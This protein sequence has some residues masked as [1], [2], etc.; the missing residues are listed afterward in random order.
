MKKPIFFLLTIS[1]LLA[2]TKTSIGQQV[3][4][5][6]KEFYTIEGP[7]NFV[8]VKSDNNTK[9]VL[10]KAET[11][12]PDKSQKEMYYPGANNSNFKLVGDNIVIVYDIWQKAN[13]TKDCSIKLLDIKSG[14]FTAPKLLY[15]TKLNSPY[16]CSE[17][18]YKPIYS[19]DKTKLAVIK[20]NISPSYNIDPEINIYDTKTL[21]VLS[22]KKIS[23]KYDGQKRIF[24][25][26]TIA[27]DDKGNITTVF[28][29]MNEKTKITTKSYSADIPFAET[30]LKNIK[31]L[32]G[33]SSSDAGGNQTSHGRFYKTL[34]DYVNDKPMPGV[35]IKNGSFSWTAFGGADFKLIDD[36]G[37]VTKE[38]SKDLPSEIFTYKRDN[39]SDPY[40]LR[41][42]DKKPYIILAAGYYCYYSLYLEQQNRYMGEGFDGELKKFK[43]GRFEELLEKYNLLEDYKKDKP[44]RE[45]KDDV[46]GYFNKTINWQ[47]KYFNLLNKK[48]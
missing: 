47:I 45:F 33:N 15:S 41:I 37:N 38:D 32:S 23:G 26:T 14:K 31:E 8:I 11:K 28:H 25:L 48:M 7:Y 44:K 13:G 34:D 29:L 19:P 5:T 16:S 22:T 18:P 12:I 9:K 35:R 39:F 2:F 20:D 6:D 21:N 43:E 4:K 36:A 17:L 10:Y 27:I 46:N 1:L 24:D 40:I 42:M 30:D 3:I